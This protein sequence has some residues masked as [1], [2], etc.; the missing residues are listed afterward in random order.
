VRQATG[1]DL[2]CSP[3]QL[4]AVA[5][6]I[7]LAANVPQFGLDDVAGIVRFIETAVI[8]VSSL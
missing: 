8:G 4:I 1:S 2:L 7:P 5:A 3:P 6:D